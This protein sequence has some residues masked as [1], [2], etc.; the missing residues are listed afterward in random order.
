MDNKY[1]LK[2]EELEKVSGGST[3]GINGLSGSGIDIEID[4]LGFGFPS[5]EIPEAEINGLKQPTGLPSDMN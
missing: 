2:D 1:T 5:P 3:V 4:N